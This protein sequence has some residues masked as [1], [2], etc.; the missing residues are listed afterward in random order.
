MENL[1]GKILNKLPTCDR[2][3]RWFMLNS[4]DNHI[5]KPYMIS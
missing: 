1:Q 2:R 5:N 4:K 3:R